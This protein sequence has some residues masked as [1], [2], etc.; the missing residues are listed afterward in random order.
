MARTRKARVIGDVA[1]FYLPYVEEAIECEPGIRIV[2]LKR[3]GAEVVRAFCNWLDGARGLATDHWSR[4]PG[5]GFYHDPYWTRIFPQYD[6]GNREEGI[7]RYCEEYYR[8]AGELAGKWPENVRIFEWRSVL[9]SEAGQREMLSFVGIPAG[10]QVIDISGREMRGGGTSGTSFGVQPLGCSAR[11]L[12]PELQTDPRRCVILVPYN[13]RIV[14]PCEDSLRQLERRGYPVRRVVGFAA[15]DQARNQLASDALMHGFEE[16]MWIDSDVAF[17]PEA[18][19][20][21]RRHNLPIVCGIY[22]QKGKR[23]IAAHVMP[24]TPKMTFGKNGGLHEVRYAGAGFLLI[25]REVYLT[26]QEQLRLPMCNERFGKPMIPFFQPMTIPL[27]DGYWYLAEDY[28]FCERARQCGYKI[29]ADTSIRLWHWG[30][31][32]YGWEDAGVDRPR[33]GSFTLNFSGAPGGAPG[34]E[35]GRVVGLSDRPGGEEDG[36]P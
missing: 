22:P 23:A 4:R 36:K 35:A 19:E 5:K 24:G 17:K 8:V 3:P 7:A 32:G 26:M 6:V 20:A 9:E 27:D 33:H 11:R 30:T 31:C 1:S 14:E 21:L 18:V 28:A 10:K 13:D 12:K 25:R 15:V 2:C 34:E 29:V 16:T